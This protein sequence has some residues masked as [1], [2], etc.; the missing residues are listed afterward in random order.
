MPDAVKEKGV[1]EMLLE[2]GQALKQNEP[3]QVE[4]DD[5]QDGDHVFICITR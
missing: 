2:I 1:E 3:F 5:Q 4:V